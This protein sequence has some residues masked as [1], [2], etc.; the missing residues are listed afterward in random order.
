MR[1]KIATKKK[2]I[3]IENMAR[4]GEKAQILCTLMKKIISEEGKYTFTK[5]SGNSVGEADT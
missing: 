3:K 4:K 2:E 1:K 5:A